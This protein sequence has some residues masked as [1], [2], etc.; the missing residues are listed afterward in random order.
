VIDFDTFLLVLPILLASLTL[1]ELAH[2][3]IADRL[4]DP[5]P[6]EQGRLTLNP[7]VHMDPIGT[8]VLVYTLLFSSFVF[9]WARPVL[10]NP[11]YF[12]RAREGMAI[13][14][15]AGP[16]TNFV[17][18]VVCLLCFRFFDIEPGTRLYEVVGTAFI[19]NVVLGVFNMFPIPP[20]D[21]SR[22]VA[23]LMDRSTYARWV[24]LDPYG[25]IILLGLIFLFREQFQTF[26]RSTLN[27]IEGLVGVNVVA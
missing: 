12:R 23:V 17:L 8:A 6:R 3:L 24:Q 25:F 16:A 1:H 21:G 15:I 2:G 7:I 18:A 9:G 5:T 10:V 11:R 22:V 19:V 4:G 13:V 27:A 20:L 26:F 14:A